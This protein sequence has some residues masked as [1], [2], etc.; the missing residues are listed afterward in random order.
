M[1]ATL[2]KYYNRYFGTNTVQLEASDTRQVKPADQKIKTGPLVRVLNKS[3]KAARVLAKLVYMVSDS[4]KLCCKVLKL[5][6]ALKALKIKVKTKRIPKHIQKIKKTT[7]KKQGR[8]AAVCIKD[9]RT[10]IASVASCTKLVDQVYTI[11]PIAQRWIPGFKMVSPFIKPASLYPAALSFQKAYALSGKL[12]VFVGK[13]DPKNVDAIKE[14]LKEFQQLNLKQIQKKLGLAK[15]EKLSDTVQQLLTSLD[16]E[17][18]SDAS[19]KA[20][21]SLLNALNRKSKVLVGCKSLRCAAKVGRMVGGFMVLCNLATT[22]GHLIIYSA[23]LLSF[24]NWA[25]Q[26]YYFQR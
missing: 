13:M 9:T 15:T 12:H 3:A 19:I 16:N 4:G 25:G 21:V 10:I 5:T 18:K 20:S 7:G 22:Y 6:K 24:A 23:C 11:S 2:V 26:R 8:I 14:V 1:A 17:T